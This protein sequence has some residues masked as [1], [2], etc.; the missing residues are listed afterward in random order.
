MIMPLIMS[1]Y[2]TNLAYNSASVMFGSMD[3]R[4]ALA[5]HVTGNESPRDLI[6]LERMDKAMQLQGIMAQTNL[7]AAWAMQEAAQKMREKD[8]EQK[9]RLMDAGAIFV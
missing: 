3:R 5:N 7:Q 1:M 2:A 9:K 8:N 6:T 4:M